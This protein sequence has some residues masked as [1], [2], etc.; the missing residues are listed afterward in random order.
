M[1]YHPLEGFFPPIAP[2]KTLE[3]RGP[4]GLQ[5][6]VPSSGHQSTKSLEA[7]GRAI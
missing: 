2:R 5:I 3:G 4:K 1:C 6:T 7:Q